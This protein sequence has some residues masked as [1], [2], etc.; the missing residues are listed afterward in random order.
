MAVIPLWTSLDK[1]GANIKSYSSVFSIKGSG[2]KW[3]LRGY[4][5]EKGSYNY[6]FKAPFMFLG[7]SVIS[8]LYMNF[9]LLIYS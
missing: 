8:T 9:V 7:N 1:E 3:D 2:S 4:L 5:I 6:I